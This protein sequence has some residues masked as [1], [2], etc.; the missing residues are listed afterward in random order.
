MIRRDFEKETVPLSILVDRTA[1]AGRGRGIFFENAAAT[2]AGS[3]NTMASFGRGIVSVA[4]SAARAYDLGLVPIASGQRRPQSPRFCSSVEGRDC[5]ETGISAQERAIT[6]ATLGRAD[7][8]PDDLVTPGHIVPAVVADTLD[9]DSALCELA[10]RYC[11][12][13]SGAR[14]V[15]WCDILNVNGDIASSADCVALSQQLGV[16][17]YVC[18]DLSVVEFRRLPEALQELYFKIR[19]GDLSLDQFA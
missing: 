10:F 12:R 16:D 1:L 11:E 7:C 14:A 13:A 15:T 9:A 19:G 17:L 3:V 18:R 6:A 5:T 2:S 8:E 4:M